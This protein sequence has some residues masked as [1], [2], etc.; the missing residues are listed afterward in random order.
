MTDDDA[1]TTLSDLWDQ[2][3]TRQKLV[4]IMS[5]LTAA[6]A[7]LS[8]GF[9]I[10]STLSQGSLEKQAAQY[11]RQINVLQ[12]DLA[13]LKRQ[14][15]DDRITDTTDDLPQLD[16]AKLLKMTLTEFTNKCG[17]MKMDFPEFAKVYYGKKAGRLRDSGQD[18][19]ISDQ[20]FQC[21]RARCNV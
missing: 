10:G 12:N 14:E 8:A 6:L 7:L 15:S 3:S 18:G 13:T 21:D 9:G 11:E 4:V 19:I 2:F 20:Q 16:D 1:L 5:L 17:E